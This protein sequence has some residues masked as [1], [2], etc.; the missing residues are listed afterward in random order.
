MK[1][2]APLILSLATLAGLFWFLGSEALVFGDEDGKKDK[3]SAAAPAVADASQEKPIFPH[4]R[5]VSRLWLTKGET[6]RDCQVCHDFNTPNHEPAS[7]CNACHYNQ[8]GTGAATLNVRGKVAN[9]ERT[10]PSFRHEDH[11]PK[12]MKCIECHVDPNSKTKFV[13]DEIWIP[14]GLGWCTKCH[15]PSINKGYE[16]NRRADKPSVHEGFQ[17]TINQTS[18]MVGKPTDVFL[19]SDHMTAAELSSGSPKVCNECHK[20]MATADP[21]IGEK[22]FRES[23]CTSCH[24]TG[25]NQPMG[26]GIKEVLG[27]KPV[28]KADYTF[29]HSDHLSEKAL[30]K[31]GRLAREGCFVCNTYNAGAASEAERY[32]VK[33]RYETFAGCVECHKQGGVPGGIA[34]DIPDHGEVDNCY[35][36]HS[37]EGDD[38]NMLTNRPMVSVDRRH[39]GDYRFLAHAHP[40][41]TGKDGKTRSCTECPRVRAGRAALTN[42]SKALQAR[43]SPQP[44]PEDADGRVRGLPHRT[45]RARPHGDGGRPGRAHQ[46]QVEELPRVPP[47]GGQDRAEPVEVRRAQRKDRDVLAPRSP[48]R[49]RTEA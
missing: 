30:K 23:D 5:H 45:S 6:K 12:G 42:S 29:F 49:S 25:L 39:P 32:P 33:P 43:S 34:R 20:D 15:D 26:I 44:G 4:S 10:M 2:L 19:H 22:L 47:G 24:I 35:G 7:E 41:I 27:A 8:K 36:C 9:Y 17:R 40:H 37:L 46:L 14:R 11:V 31:D 38:T 21:K 18:T 1:R 13:Q 48:F 16:F 3:S 28:S